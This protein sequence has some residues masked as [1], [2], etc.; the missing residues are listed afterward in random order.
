MV[1]VILTGEETT[2]ALGAHLAQACGQTGAVIFLIGTLGAGKTTL[3]RGFLQALGYQGT[4][5][6]PTYTL[7]EPYTLPPWQLYHFDLYRLNDPQELEFIGIQDYFNPTAICLVEWPERGASLLPP[8]DLQ[9]T[10]EYRGADNRLARLEAR[11]ERGNRLLRHILT[12]IDPRKLDK[13]ESYL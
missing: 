2:R 7:V 5:K 1:K 8:P 12:E 6:S 11:T 4:V 13:N 3:A 9:V 10:L